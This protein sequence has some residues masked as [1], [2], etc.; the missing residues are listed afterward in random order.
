[1]INAYN[2]T[3]PGKL[4]SLKRQE[5]QAMLEI[6][7]SLNPNLPTKNLITI[8][9]NTIKAQLGV[10]K[11]RFITSELN[12]NYQIAYNYGFLKEAIF[13]LE[14]LN[15]FTQTTKII[16]T[17]HEIWQQELPIEYVIPLGVKDAPTAWFLIADFADSDAEALNDIIFIE[18]V[19]NILVVSLEN[20]R[21]FDEK[22]RQEV[23]QRELE[24]AER[25]QKQLLPSSFIIHPAV[26]IFALNIAHHKV[27]GDFYD[28]IPHSEDEFFV[29]M[30]DVSGKGVAAALLVANLQANI[31][32]QVLIQPTIAKIV[33]KINTILYGITSG[34][35]FVTLFLSKIN[36][37]HNTIEYVN[38]GHNP[39]MLVQ[40]DKTIKEL[41]TG[42]IPVGIMP[43]INIETGIETISNNDLL[44]LY[45]D[46]ILEQENDKGDQ[47]G[48]QF[49]EYSLLQNHHLSPKEIVHN[50]YKVL[51]DFANKQTSVDDVTLLALRYQNNLAQPETPR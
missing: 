8:V 40:P 29:V 10:R 42:A 5:A 46:G 27:G 18:T 28:L 6:V 37:T 24:V 49:L 41:S 45:T 26:D 47:L 4:L 17:Q 35:K 36:T 13:P 11:L 48:I 30:A 32:A 31:R 12:D 39:P 43:K 15:A 50:L 2:T 1:M 33:E 23:I 3:D 19:G 16:P 20:I 44:F 21:L 38:C 34:E 25:I 14:L 22:I 51:N 7:R 9:V